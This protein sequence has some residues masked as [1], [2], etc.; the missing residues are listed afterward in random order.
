MCNSPLLLRTKYS[1]ISSIRKEKSFLPPCRK[2]PDQYL[3][4]YSRTEKE[5]RELQPL[6]ACHRLKTWIL[7]K[8]MVRTSCSDPAA[9]G[10]KTSYS[11]RSSSNAYYISFID[12]DK[13]A[14]NSQQQ[15]ILVCNAE[16]DL[17]TIVRNLCRVCNCS[18]N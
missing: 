10:K 3:E 5:R 15:L 6:K 17:I 18:V 2:H 16:N 14:S 13:Q 4:Y 12:W 9:L 8:S 7:T 1:L 11:S